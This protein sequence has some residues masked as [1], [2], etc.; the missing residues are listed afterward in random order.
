MNYLQ[1]LVQ[2]PAKSPVSFR[3]EFGGTGPIPI[4]N[5]YEICGVLRDLRPSNKLARREWMRRTP[6]RQ[7]IAPSLSETI[8][9]RAGRK[10]CSSV[11]VPAHWFT[12][13]T[14]ST[15]HTYN[16][17]YAS[18]W[19]GGHGHSAQPGRPAE[20][21]GGC[22]SA[23]VSRGLSASPVCGACRSFRPIGRA[24]DD[25]GPQV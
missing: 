15:M 20:A 6:V 7:W 25:L 19:I 1:P 4:H 2:M 3:A 10:A 16:V 13:P 21:R 23:A 22:N 24:K 8:N 5:L 9:F 11:V 14:I 17:P 18:A 12:S